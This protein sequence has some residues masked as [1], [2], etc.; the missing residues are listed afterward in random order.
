MT[1]SVQTRVYIVNGSG[2]APQT[3]EDDNLERNYYNYVK[4][5]VNVNG[6]GEISHYRTFCYGTTSAIINIIS[7]FSG[8][9]LTPMRGM[10]KKQHKRTGDQE[11]NKTL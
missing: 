3:R 10:R 9:G 8:I 5:N 2:C 7:Q 4:E 1:D 11:D 6:S